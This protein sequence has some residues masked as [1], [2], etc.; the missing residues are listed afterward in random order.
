M[1]TSTFDPAQFLPDD[2]LERIRDRAA[3]VDAA[4]VFPQEDLD[5]L[6]SAGYLR[7]LVPEDRGGFGLSGGTF[8]LSL[9]VR[10]GQVIPRVR[11]G[12]GSMCHL[13]LR[14]GEPGEQDKRHRGE[15]RSKTDQ[16]AWR[17]K[18]WRVPLMSCP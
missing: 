9:H 18:H 11:A 15:S 8:C 5:E 10:T 7:I 13:C 2:L 3:A 14:R 4:N 1:T 16:Q 12:G 6:R 17:V